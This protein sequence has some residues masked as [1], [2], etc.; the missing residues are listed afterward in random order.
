MPSLQD[1]SNQ[2]QCLIQ[3]QTH[4]HT[5]MHNNYSWPTITVASGGDPWSVA[6]A[7]LCRVQALPAGWA[8][9]FRLRET[10]ALV[11]HALWQRTGT[12]LR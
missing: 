10:S 5:E 8:G 2:E 1:E 6:V 7:A 9:M 3:A 11:T 12:F 4:K